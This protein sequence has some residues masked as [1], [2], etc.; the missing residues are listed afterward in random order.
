MGVWIRKKIHR[1]KW[2]EAEQKAREGTPC[3]NATAESR[4]IAEEVVQAAVSQYVSWEW[5]VEAVMAQRLQ[6][7]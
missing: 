3:W 1:V 4:W 5:T 6:R 7:V 2:D